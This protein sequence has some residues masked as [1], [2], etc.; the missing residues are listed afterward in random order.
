MQ[1]VV[2]TAA[3]AS[4]PLP[5]AQLNCRLLLVPQKGWDSGLVLNK[6][7]GLYPPNGN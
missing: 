1:V 5:A 2:S 6:D 7:L 4:M 3:M